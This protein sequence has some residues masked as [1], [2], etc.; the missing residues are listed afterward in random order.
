MSLKD[1]LLSIFDSYSVRTKT[2]GKGYPADTLD[3]KTRNRILLVIRDLMVGKNRSPGIQSGDHTATFWED[4]HNRLQHLYGR[5]K[6]SDNEHERDSFRDGLGFVLS[7]KPPEFFDF[8]EQ[9]FRSEVMWRVLHDENELVEAINEIFRSDRTP[10]Q[11]TPVVKR[12][13]PDRG[14]WPGGIPRGGMVIHTVAYPKVVRVDEEAAHAEAVVPALSALS[15][16]AYGGGNDEFRRALE[17]YRKGDFEDCLAKCGSA[18]E[19][20]L[21]VLCHKNAIP[22]DPKKDALGSLLEKVLVK[23]ALDTVTFKEPVRCVYSFGSRRALVLVQESAKTVATFQL[24]RQHG[25]PPRR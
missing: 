24:Y 16:P 14:F 10:Y 1:Q 7:C 5:P 25:R 11:M 15:D 12:E 6:L 4:I 17:D 20:V 18:F 22:F 21:K 3:E 9:A 2:R 23:S 19:S 13:E 8:L